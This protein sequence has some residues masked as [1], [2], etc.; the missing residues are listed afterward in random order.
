MA[1]RT[2]IQDKLA[3]EFNDLRA[4]G[5]LKVQHYLDALAHGMKK[6]ITGSEYERYVANIFSV[7]QLDLHFRHITDAVFATD[8][9]ASMRIFKKEMQRLLR[10]NGTS[11]E[12]YLLRQ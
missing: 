8:D 10:A 4:K 7:F 11:E 9:T 3:K 12:H 6:G 2:K 5:G 1:K